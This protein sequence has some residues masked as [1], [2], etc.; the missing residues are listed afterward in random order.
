M[1]I[2]LVLI[3]GIASVMLNAQPNDVQS[4][5]NEL[6][7]EHRTW[8][9]DIVTAGRTVNS[10]QKAKELAITESQSI[11]EQ[12]E[13]VMLNQSN[14]I[15]I[16][17]GKTTRY[18]YPRPERKALLEIINNAE[19]QLNQ[20]QLFELYRTHIAIGFIEQIEARFIKNTHQAFKNNIKMRATG[21][22]MRILAL[23]Y[24]N[25]L[26]EPHG[27]DKYRKNKA[28]LFNETTI[29]N[30]VTALTFS[31]ADMPEYIVLD[32]GEMQKEYALSELKLY[33][34][35]TLA[36]YEPFGYDRLVITELL[37]SA[38]NKEF[39]RQTRKH[40]KSYG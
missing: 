40:L 38:L 3:L 29:A 19:N 20:K 26:E 14:V 11:L 2:C 16:V 24:P 5:I 37:I 12:L 15:V 17:N 36:Q 13:Q 33:L 22:A 1:K 18:H 7:E 21:V 8:L 23:A 28:Q 32:T 39:A 6:A 25:K 34:S 27:D 10:P 9:I 35:N 31:E 30:L 4:A